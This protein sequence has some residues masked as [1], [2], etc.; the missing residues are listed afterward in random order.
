MSTLMGGSGQQSLPEIFWGD[1][2]FNGGV[3]LTYISRSAR[4]CTPKISITVQTQP[5]NEVTKGF[6]YPECSPVVDIV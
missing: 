3:A 6:L 4:E 2:E 1:F 5:P